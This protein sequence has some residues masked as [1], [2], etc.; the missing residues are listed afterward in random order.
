MP[1]AVIQ[2]WAG[3]GTD[4]TNYDEI[5]RRMGVEEDPPAGLLVH[6][7]GTA[8]DGDFRIFDVWETTE[9]WEAFRDGRLLPSVETLVS[10][11]G[12]TGS[13]PVVHVYE[14]HGFIRPEPGLV[15]C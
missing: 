2:E 7:A 5:G 3:A 12:R 10:E 4:T 11:Q 15:R 1:V 13:P 14:L 6:T 9:A 8:E